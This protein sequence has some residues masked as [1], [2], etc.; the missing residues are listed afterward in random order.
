M[1]IATRRSLLAAGLALAAPRIGAAQEVFPAR[2]I[3][4]V[5]PWAAGGST[6]AIGRL[7]AQVM[8]AD[9]GQPIIIENRGGASGTIGHAHVARQRPDG[10]TLLL[11]TNSTYAMA[12]H[13]MRSLPYDN[14]AAFTPVSLVA[15]SPQSLA[16]HPSIP[17]E[18]VAEFIAHCRARPDQLSYSSAGVG[19]SSHLA[20]ELF[21][22]KTGT[23][24]V[25]VPYRGGGPSAQGLLAGEVA[26]SFVDLVTA[27]PFRQ[28][29]QLK[30]LGVSTAQRSDLAPDL[31]T[32]AESGVP[33]FDSS[34]D[35]AMF[36]PAGVPAP[37]LARISAALGKAV[38]DAETQ[39]RIR[40]MGVELIGST[41]AQ[42]E[43]YWPR[44]IE[45]WGEII[46]AQNIRA[47]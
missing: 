25:H 10:Y 31:P 4:L 38:Q 47:D 16:V 14:R 46:R 20:T 32:V 23:R 24:L 36:M 1:T 6:D 30:V 22:A 43:A 29:R 44:E 2:P 21:L 12:P 3:T 26:M 42:L 28:N 5:I 8:A 17:V 33:G 35:A 39:R 11:G 45:K 7:L 34:T 41:P 40:A 27:I 37:I 15:R 18:T 9:L 13:M 19:A